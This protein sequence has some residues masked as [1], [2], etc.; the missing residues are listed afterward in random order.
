MKYLTYV[1]AD[2]YPVFYD[3]SE[4][5]ALLL[6]AGKQILPVKS[7]KKEGKNDVLFYTH[8]SGC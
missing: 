6:K 3:S 7:C 2:L 8:P 5:N 4:T 1:I